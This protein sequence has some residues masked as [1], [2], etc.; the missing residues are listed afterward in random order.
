[1]P[2][3]KRRGGIRT[4]ERLRVAGFQDLES[5]DALQPSVTFCKNG[6]RFQVFRLQSVAPNYTRGGEE[7]E[8]LS[9]AVRAALR[10]GARTAT[11]AA[12]LDS[13]HDDIEP[14]RRAGTLFPAAALVLDLSVRERV[15]ASSDAR[16]HVVDR[17]RVLTR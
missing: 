5:R 13:L 8:A 16:A 15:D 6:A 14:S 9:R 10:L 17:V 3:S 12:C 1:M 2:V 7:V 4:L 11:A